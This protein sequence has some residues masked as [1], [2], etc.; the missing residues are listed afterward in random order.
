MVFKKIGSISIE[1][2]KTTKK[3]LNFFINIDQVI[4]KTDRPLIIFPQATR[5][6]PNDRSPFKKGAARIYKELNINCLPVAINSGHVWPKIGEKKTNRIIT[7]SILKP[8]KPGLNKEKFLKTLE[9]S[10]YSELDFIR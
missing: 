2:E 4:S 7:I 1:R 10:I 9:E 3:N 6:L 8:I 5:V